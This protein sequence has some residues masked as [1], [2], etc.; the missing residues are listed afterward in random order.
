MVLSCPAC[1][2]STYVHTCILFALILG[3]L[4]SYP[5]PSYFLV[6]LSLSRFSPYL[7][8]SHSFFGALLLFLFSLPSSLLPSLVHSVKLHLRFVLVLPIRRLFIAACYVVVACQGFSTP[9]R[10]RFILFKAS[11]ESIVLEFIARVCSFGPC[12]IFWIGSV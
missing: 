3:L 10:L 7:W 9:S 4:P 11:I 8:S 1:L 12:F 6:A 2:A 5:F